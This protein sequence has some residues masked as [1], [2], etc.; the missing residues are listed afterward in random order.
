AGDPPEPLPDTQI[1]RDLHRRW[2]AGESPV[3]VRRQEDIASAKV[4]NATPNHRAYA[5]CVYRVH[6]GVALYPS[7]DSIF[8]EVHPDDTLPGLLAIEAALLNFVFLNL[9]AIYAPMGVGH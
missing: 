9:E 3:A 7:E 1:V 8:G 6:N 4:L 5:D 2:K